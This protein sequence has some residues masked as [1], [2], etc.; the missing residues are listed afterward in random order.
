MR[1]ICL[2]VIAEPTHPGTVSPM[3]VHKSEIEGATQDSQTE[4]VRFH[5]RMAE[6]TSAVVHAVISPVCFSV[7]KERSFAR[8]I[9]KI[10]TWRPI[11][12]LLTR[13]GS[14]A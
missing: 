4:Q 1:I 9:S 12:R 3:D 10:K 7:A 5:R 14:N 13:T 8:V 11:V 6:G 2:T